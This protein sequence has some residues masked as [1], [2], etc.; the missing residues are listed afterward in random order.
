MLDRNRL[1]RIPLFHL[2]NQVENYLNDE[3]V[4]KLVDG[5]MF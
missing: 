1:A 2:D 4:E 5:S 3:Q